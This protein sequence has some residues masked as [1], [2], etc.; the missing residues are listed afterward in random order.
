MSEHD[1]EQQFSRRSE[2]FDVPLELVWK[3]RTAGSAFSLACEASGLD[4]KEIYCELGIDPATWSR[5][6]SDQANLPSNMIGRFCE[7]VD[8]VIYVQWICH[9]VGHYPVLTKTEAERR[10]EA[11][12]R[13]AAELEEKNRVLTELLH[14]RALA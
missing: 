10:A 7:I 11:A 12:E 2:R 13:R 9:Q 5:I 6:K 4:D 1:Q 14:G 3:R 8:N